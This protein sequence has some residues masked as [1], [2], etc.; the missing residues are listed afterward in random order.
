M[1]TTGLPLN[2]NT[3]AEFKRVFDN[4]AAGGNV[5]DPHIIRGITKVEVVAVQIRIGLVTVHLGWRQSSKRAIGW[6]D[7][8]ASWCLRSDLAQGLARGGSVPDHKRSAIIR[9]PEIGTDKRHSVSAA[10]TWGCSHQLNKVIAGAKAGGV[11]GSGII[12]AD[13]TTLFLKPT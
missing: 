4:S 10:T 11:S 2:A 5:A 1:F 6:P 3:P 13:D 8:R 7:C 9:A 12:N